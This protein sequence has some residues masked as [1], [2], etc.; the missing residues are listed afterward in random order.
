MRTIQ[1]YLPNPR[2]TEIHRIFVKAKPDVAWNTARHFD[3]SG[4]PWV[5]LLFDIRTLPDKL[6]GRPNA[7]AS[8]N[9][10]KAKSDKT[11]SQK[12]LWQ[13]LNGLNNQFAQINLITCVLNGIACN[14]RTGSSLY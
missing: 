8:G 5:K 6:M 2:H 14:N 12:N 9:F 7:E 10:R 11:S 1:S 4:V 3:M 13:L